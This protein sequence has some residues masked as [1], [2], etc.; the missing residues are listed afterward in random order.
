MLMGDPRLKQSLS[1]Y[2]THVGCMSIYVS[3][4]YTI[5]CT[6]VTDDDHEFTRQRLHIEH[7][8]YVYT[9]HNNNNI[10]KGPLLYT[11]S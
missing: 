4:V 9:I 8:Q 3:T 11:N 10:L 5:Q 2:H 7:T 1:T 6:I